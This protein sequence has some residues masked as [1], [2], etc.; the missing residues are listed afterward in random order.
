M[1]QMIHTAASTFGTLVPTGINALGRLRV[2]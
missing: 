1:K 2:L